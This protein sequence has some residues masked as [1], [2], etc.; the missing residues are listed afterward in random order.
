MCN[1]AISDVASWDGE[2]YKITLI[3]PNT[4]FSQ[5]QLLL[6]DSMYIKTEQEYF[7]LI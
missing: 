1:I 6:K 7:M 2:E 5:F 4:F 3:K